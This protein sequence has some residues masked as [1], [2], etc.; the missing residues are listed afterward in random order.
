VAL[1]YFLGRGLFDERAG[2]A[3]G[4]LALTSPLVWFHGE[5]ALSYMPEAMMSALFA[6][7]CMRVLR[8]ESGLYWLC[9]VILGV[10]GGIRQNSMVFLM[11]LW[12]YSMKGIGPK[13]AALG[14]LIFGASVLAW[15]LPML[16]ATGGYAPYKAALAS[17]WTGS[18]WQGVS[19]GRVMSN[20]ANVADI[21]VCG[22]GAAL[23]P[24]LAFIYFRL[25][26]GPPRAWDREKTVFFL[27]W[28]APAVLF[29]TLIFFQP[30]APGYVLIYLVGL[31]VLAGRALAAV[32]EAGARAGTW[33]SA[34]K[35]MRATLTF[36]A[37]VNIALFLLWPYPFSAVSVRWHDHMI[38]NYVKAVRAGFSPDD[39][40]IIGTELFFCGYRHAM[41]YLPEFKVHD[42]QFIMTEKGPRIFWCRDGVTHQERFIE[43]LPTT[44]RFIYFVSCDKEDLA[45]LPMGAKAEPVGGGYYLVH[46]DS[47]AQLCGAGVLGPEMAKAPGPATA[48]R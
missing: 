30:G 43:P 31:L 29:H 3:A 9:A 40:E 32:S 7:V 41:Y 28:M 5:V 48:S 2:L 34:D 1:V 20:T 8:G 27:V 36:V 16:A 4:V 17:Q 15:F 37:A 6:Y 44:R 23:V 11:P 25:R 14:V 33:L 22:I 42:N 39:T 18:V 47:I 46:Y 45:A 35:L 19:A 10:S 13:R 21:V 12:L 26:G 24:V 38:E